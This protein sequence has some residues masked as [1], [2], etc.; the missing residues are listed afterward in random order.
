MFIAFSIALP[1]MSVDFSQEPERLG[2]GWVSAIAFSPDGTILAAWYDADGN[3]QT[4]E[5]ELRLLD[6]QTHQQV[7]ELK[8]LGPIYA[9][10]FSPDGT[11]LAL[12]GE[13][14]TI[15]LWD[16]AEQNQVGVMQSP[17][18]WGL[19][20]LAFSPDGK[21]L[22]SSGSGNNTVRLWDV[23]TLE[24]VGVLRGHTKGIHSIVFSPDG[25]L[26]FSGGHR[27]HEAVRAWDVQTQRQVGELIGHLDITYDL[28]F[29]PD[30][31]ILASAGGAFDKAVYLWDV[32]TQK[33]VGVLGGHPAHV[34]SVAFSPDGKFLAS[35]VTGDDTVHLWDVEGQEQVGLLKGH[36]ALDKPQVAFS[37]DG[38]WLAA[39]SINGV[40]FWELN[41]PAA[42]SRTSAFGPKPADGT[43]HTDTWVNLEWRAGD[44][45]VSHDVYLGDDFEDVNTGTGDTFRGNQLSTD[46]IVGLTGFPYPD[47]L[48]QGSTYYWRIDEVNDNEPDSPWRGPVWSFSIPPKIAYNPVPSDGA[49][50]VGLNVELSWTAGLGAALHTVYFGDNL[51]DVNNATGG[52]QQ[53]KTTYTPGPLEFA[54]TY[55]WRVDEFGVGRGA[56]THKGDVWSFTTVNFIVVDDFEDYTDDDA[57]GEAIWQ[58][59]IDGVGVPGN[60]AQVGYFLPPYAEQTIVHGGLQ[61]MPVA[62]ENTASAA[63]SEVELT[64]TSPADWTEN[65]LSTLSIWFSGKPDNA[66]ERMFVALNGS[67]AVYHDNPNATQTTVWTEWLLNLQAFAGVDLAN[68]STITI[69][70]GTKSSPSTGGAGTVYFDNIRLYR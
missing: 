49:E 22:A 63:N 12:G 46:Y 42:T 14:N 65:G 52:F 7:G 61:S 37:S 34:V 56:E 58:H 6:V 41:L 70:F 29:S 43:L 4:V 68:V 9:I 16:V 35:A 51:D 38:K 25:R 23:Q 59:W 8:G 5:G 47:G 21:T 30:R 18:I 17:T 26:L 10:A 20:C 64:L 19:Y 48:V 11:L 50:F 62:Y 1:A 54:T 53:G 67:T 2:S 28:V 31:T 45:A 36:D 32:Q 15:R 60:G 66:A 3:W 27:E 40:E 55:C 33:Q 57:A 24:Q 69:G 44:S 13:G 39:G